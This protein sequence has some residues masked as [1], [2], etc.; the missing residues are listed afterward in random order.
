[1]DSYSN[2]KQT[3]NVKMICYNSKN[4]IEKNNPII[5]VI[6]FSQALFPLFC[7]VESIS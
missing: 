6:A 7:R 4:I 3:K 2:N 1:M 5:N